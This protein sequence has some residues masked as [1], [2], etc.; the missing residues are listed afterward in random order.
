[1]LEE[2]GFE[3]ELRGLLAAVGGE[4][5]RTVYANGDALSYV[6]LVYEGVVT[7][8]DGAP[9]GDEVSELGWFST[10]EIARLPL[11]RFV[12]LLGARGLLAI[13]PAEDDGGTLR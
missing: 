11:E 1:V 2:T 3:V 4:E 8:G 13:R 5:C 6:A 12:E 7:D 9:D 10:T